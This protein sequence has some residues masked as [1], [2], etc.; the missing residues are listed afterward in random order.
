MVGYRRSEG[1]EAA[2]TLADLYAR[3]RLF[4]NFFQPSFKLAEKTREGAQVRK[5]YHPPAPPCQRLLAALR[6]PPAVRERVTALKASLDPV[7]LL[8]EIRAAQQRLMGI[9]DKPMTGDA[10][11]PTLG[12]FLA[13]LRPAWKEG[14]E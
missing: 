3:V 12:G 5:R 6:A 14:E 2:A 10:R 13:G 9:A 11:A 8:A 1:L 7:S 4:V